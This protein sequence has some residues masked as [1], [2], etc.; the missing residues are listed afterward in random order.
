MS[1]TPRPSEGGLND[2]TAE[3]LALKREDVIRSRVLRSLGNPSGVLRVNVLPLWGNNFRV[4]VLIGENATA[5][6]I[7]NSYFVTADDHGNIL[8]SEPPIPKQY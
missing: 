1:Q 6:E 7:P 5:V 8:R 3:F 4:N 2:A